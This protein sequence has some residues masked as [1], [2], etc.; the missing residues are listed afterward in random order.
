[1][2]ER[3]HA[4]SPAWDDDRLSAFVDNELSAEERAEVER[5]LQESPEAREVVD[6]L[7]AIRAAI[8][9]LDRRV[10]P[11]S[12]VQRVLD[13]A[14][15]QMLLGP[16]DRM[17]GKRTWTF[18]GWKLWPILGLATAASIAAL[19]LVQRQPKLRE[20]AQAPQAASETE[21]PPVEKVAETSL[22]DMP[23]AAAGHPENSPKIERQPS[24]PLAAPPSG[25]PALEDTVKTTRDS[26]S[27]DELAA[28]AGQSDRELAVAESPPQEEINLGRDTARE[29]ASA[30]EQLRAD[31]FDVVLVAQ[32]HSLDQMRTLQRLRKTADAMNAGSVRSQG[33]QKDQ[34]TDQFYSWVATDEE[35]D[36]LVDQLTRSGLSVARPQTPPHEVD[37][38]LQQLPPVVAT[39]P[40]YGFQAPAEHLEEFQYLGEFQRKDD[41]AVGRQRSNEL[42]AASRGGSPSERAE[43]RGAPEGVITPA[44]DQQV[45]GPLHAA[46]KQVAPAKQRVLLIL[47]SPAAGP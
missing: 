14:E 7:Q 46:G 29:V 20:L 40:R 33:D 9:Q 23:A 47:Q 13:Q 45:L 16:S 30:A 31:A 37:F 1:M 2:S 15:Q 42:P 19:A 5:W 3:D 26:A 11:R 21:R 24:T 39:E 27:H 22:P 41:S 44:R 10:L 17:P 18:G 28:S 4:H 34:P 43:Y 25:G 36:G 35:I 12:L 8:Q 6:E 38:W 32:A